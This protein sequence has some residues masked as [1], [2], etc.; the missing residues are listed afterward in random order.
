MRAERP[1]RYETCDGPGMR[2]IALSLLLCLGLP[3]AVPADQRVAT[4][5]RNVVFRVGDGV[6]VRVIDLAGH[7]L[8][9]TNG[10]P[11]F[12]NVSSYVV[13]V[14]AARVAMTPETPTNLMKQ[15]AFARR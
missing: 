15:N 12:D 10:A 14:D 4:R 13:A 8:S 11:V 9:T 3:A 5:M 6:E 7:L 1:F 2:R